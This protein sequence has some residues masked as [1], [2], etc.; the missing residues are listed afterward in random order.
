[1]YWEVD[2]GNPSN[3]ATVTSSAGANPASFTITPAPQ[4]P[5]LH[6]LYLYAAYGTEGGT[7]SNVAANQADST[8]NAPEL[9]N[10]TALLFTVVPIPTTTSMTADVNPQ[11]SGNN[12]TFTATVT[13]TQS[14]GPDLT[15]TVLFYDGAT[16]L[17]IRTLNLV[18]GSYIANLQTNTLSVGTH[19]ITATYSGD[20]NYAGSSGSL[21]QTIAGPPAA[22]TVVSGGGQTTTYGTAFASPLVAKV[23]GF[24]G[25]PGPRGHRD[26]LRGRPQLFACDCE[27]QLVRTGVGER[28]VYKRR[29]LHGICLGERRQRAGQFSADGEQ[30]RFDSDSKQRFAGL[31]RGEPRLYLDDY[32][33]PKRGH[34]VC[35]VRIAKPD[36]DGDNIIFRG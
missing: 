22:I 11:N 4:T 20:G 12:V 19:T 5:G 7:T 24:A 9:G 28:V 33:L 16:L 17:G 35:G 3:L 6:T 10:L 1:M 8:G 26:V 21:T 2:G 13:A 30:S 27:H 23:T 15:G 25:K 36:D 29:F 34:T 31:W 14:G 18:S 32:G